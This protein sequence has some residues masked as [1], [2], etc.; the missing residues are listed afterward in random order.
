[1]PGST[2]IDGLFT[3]Y[4]PRLIMM[5]EDVKVTFDEFAAEYNWTIALTEV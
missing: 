2:R 4:R 3:K 5:V 1:V